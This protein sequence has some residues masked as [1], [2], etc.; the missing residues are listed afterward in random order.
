[1]QDMRRSDIIDEKKCDGSVPMNEWS[2]KTRE[3][4][5]RG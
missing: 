4:N 5:M 3:L 1:M 2:D